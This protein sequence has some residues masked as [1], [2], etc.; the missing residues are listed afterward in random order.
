[1]E[2]EH[3][4]RVARRQARAD[5]RAP[6]AALHA[7]AL[8]AERRHELGEA[9]GDFLGAE[10]RLARREGKRIAGQR[11]RDHGEMLSE[12]RYELEEFDDRARPAMRNEQRHGATTARRL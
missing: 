1:M 9:V 5:E 12:Q 6:V 2:P 3:P 8:V 4:L 10:A 11:R 7:E